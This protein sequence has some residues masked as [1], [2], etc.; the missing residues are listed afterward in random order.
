M[1]Q[2][3][4]ISTRFFLIKI[5]EILLQLVMNAIA[6]KRNNRISLILNN[7]LTE[8]NR[9]ISNQL[10]SLYEET[11]D[12][13]TRSAIAYILISKNILAREKGKGEP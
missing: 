10:F 4:F 7:D 3:F 5:F 6:A 1:S 8:E 11:E 2:L 13:F 9:S 12:T